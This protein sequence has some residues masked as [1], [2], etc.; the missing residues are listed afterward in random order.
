MKIRITTKTLIARSRKAH[1]TTIYKNL[2]RREMASLF[3]ALRSFNRL[4]GN[5]PSSFEIVALT[6]EEQATWARIDAEA[7]WDRSRT[8][9]AHTASEKRS[10]YVASDLKHRTVVVIDDVVYRRS[11][12][13]KDWWYVDTA[14]KVE[15]VYVGALDGFTGLGEALAKVLG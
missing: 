8:A 10:Y 4:D 6:D 14:A 13:V 7:D 9:V 12:T 5:P 3:D 1:S 11:L 15:R 2:S